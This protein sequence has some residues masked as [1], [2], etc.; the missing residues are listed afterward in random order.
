MLLT[1][2]DPFEQLTSLQSDIDR[3]FQGKLVQNQKRDW[4][5]PD[6]LPA[7][8]IHEDKENFYFDFEAP[9]LDKKDFNI[10]INDRVLTIKGERKREE[11]KEG[12][13]YF[14]LERSYGQFTRSF[15]LP[16]TANTAKIDAEYKDGILKLKLSKKEEAKPRQ[17]EV[18]VT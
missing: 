6:W 13:N 8:D 14:R 9:G 7:V 4:V 3:L 10:S 2:W 5:N 16:E 18:K 11:K 1:K 15:E 17:I 12:K